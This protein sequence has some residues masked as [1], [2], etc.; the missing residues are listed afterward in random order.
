MRELLKNIKA[1]KN[2]KTKTRLNINTRLKY[3]VQQQAI[4]SKATIQLNKIEL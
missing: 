4:D 3:K 1:R 2:L